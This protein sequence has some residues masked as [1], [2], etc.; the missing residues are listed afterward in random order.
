[1]TGADAA[2]YVVN[3]GAS[4]A[5]GRID[6]KTLVA[7]LTGSVAKTY[8]GTSIA[9]L[10]IS[11]YILSGM[12]SGDAVALN[13]PV[14][15]AY[16]DRNA[17]NAKG[18]TVAGLGLVGA[19]AGNYV[20]NGTAAAPIGTINPKLLSVALTGNVSRIATGGTAATLTLGNYALSGFVTGESAIVTQTSGEYANASPG[21]GIEVSVVLAS[22]DFAPNAATL[23]TNYSLPIGTVKGPIGTINPA[24][25]V[26]SPAPLPDPAV[27]T[28]ALK[29]AI[30][31]ILTPA[32]APS[33]PASEAPLSGGGESGPAP[34]SGPAAGTPVEASPPSPVPA[35]KPVTPQDS[36]DI[37]DP[38]LAMVEGEGDDKPAPNA[39]RQ[40]VEST[41]LS[42]GL[43]S[44]QHSLP[45][46]NDNVPGLDT[47]FSGSGAPL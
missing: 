31:A 32:P 25:V 16:A 1:V 45:P 12:I 14:A 30:V 33:S 42:P 21:T 3:G 19:D 35:E 28:S 22:G 7:S 23:L 6:P 8:D 41:E 2:N 36:A 47:A 18:V 20:V 44:S 38:I 39:D 5:I 26:P 37:G 43:L 34:S 24:L 9:T 40:G 46:S 29:A 4:A 27:P 15:G 11:N 17:G 10:G 13:N